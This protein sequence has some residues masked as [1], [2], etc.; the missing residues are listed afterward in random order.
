[1]D[2]VDIGRRCPLHAPASLHV[3]P[4]VVGSSCVGRLCRADVPHHVPS[5]PTPASR[6][7][8]VHPQVVPATPQCS[9]GAGPS[10]ATPSAARA[11]ASAW[12]QPA[13][14]P[15]SSVHDEVRAGVGS[16]IA[17]HLCGGAGRARGHSCLLAH[18]AWCIQSLP[19]PLP[20]PHTHPAGGPCGCCKA[21]AGTLARQGRDQ[22]R[23]RE[24]GVREGG[25]PG[26]WFHGLCAHG[27]QVPG[28]MRQASG[29]GACLY[30]C[31][32]ANVMCGC[33]LALGCWPKETVAGEF[34]VWVGRGELEFVSQCLLVE[35]QQS[36]TAPPSPRL[37]VH[38]RQR[39]P[40]TLAAQPQP[41]QAAPLPPSVPGPARQQ[42]GPARQRPPAPS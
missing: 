33:G 27:A 24:G 38:H 31:A 37:A 30:A 5:L 11:A 35:C 13:A 8:A 34:W 6:A 15:S 4:I 7:V 42:G 10:A 23:L 39:L 19:S 14:E 20:P 26:P 21:G 17:W 29:R 36:G 41:Q 16:R 22:R 1:M 40:W 25:G 9:E 32:C 28:A 2:V 18:L 3:M 12:T